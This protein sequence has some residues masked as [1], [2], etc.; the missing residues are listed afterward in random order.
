MKRYIPYVESQRSEADNGIGL[1]ANGNYPLRLSL[2]MLS[3]MTMRW[4]SLVPS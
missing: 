3:E 2:R 4:I 1:N